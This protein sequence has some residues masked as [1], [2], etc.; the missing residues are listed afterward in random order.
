[1]EVWKDQAQKIQNNKTKK[2]KRKKTKNKKANFKK[3]KKKKNK[4]NI[5]TGVRCSTPA[6]TDVLQRMLLYL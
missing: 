1:M 2:Y 4:N 6:S 3:N 5:I